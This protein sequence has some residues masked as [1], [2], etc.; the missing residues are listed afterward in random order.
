MEKQFQYISDLALKYKKLAD[1]DQH[2]LEALNNLS[3]EEIEKV[4]EEYGNPEKK[5]QVVNL[6]RAEIARLLF[7]GEIISEARVEEIK[8]HIRE[9]DTG[10]FSFLQD[11]YLK[12]LK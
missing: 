7:N 5:F 12:Q 10:Y 9:R 8:N 6:V 1:N 4:F 2:L 11:E 3:K